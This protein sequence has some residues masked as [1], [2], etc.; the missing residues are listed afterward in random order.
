MVEEEEVGG[1]AGGEQAVDECLAREV[2]LE[3]AVLD[4]LFQRGQVGE[5]V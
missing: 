5:E 1:V 4:L 2:V 3:E